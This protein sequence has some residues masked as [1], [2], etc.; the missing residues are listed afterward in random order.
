VTKK[1]TKQ[2]G[3]E[4]KKEWSSSNTAVTGCTQRETL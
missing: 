2:K 1:Q 3:K 4:K